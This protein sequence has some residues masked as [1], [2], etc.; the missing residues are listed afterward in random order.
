MADES[1]TERK[2]KMIVNCAPPNHGKSTAL[3]AVWIK[4]CN[5]AENFHFLKMDTKGLDAICVFQYRGI[6]IGLCSKGDNLSDVKKAYV[7]I[8]DFLESSE[9]FIP[10]ITRN[11]E[12]KKPDI[13]ITACHIKS[14]FDK[15]MKDIIDVGKYDVSYE[16]NNYQETKPE[17]KIY[18]ARQ[19]ANKIMKMIKD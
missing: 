8:C 19:F 2:R 11:V 9:A 15:K 3:Q 14:N 16:K 7:D 13:F 17:L 4:L 1:T 18:R 12:K 6:V 10:L 5:C